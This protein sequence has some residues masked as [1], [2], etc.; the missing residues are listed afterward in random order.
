MVKFRIIHPCIHAFIHRRGKH[1]QIIRQNF[2]N[3]NFNLSY[4][5]EKYIGDK[6]AVESILANVDKTV[7]TSGR[8]NLHSGTGQGAFYSV[9]L[10]VECN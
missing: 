6:Q 8:T 9:V 7:G 3:Y 10:K 5:I 4:A 2:A 1:R